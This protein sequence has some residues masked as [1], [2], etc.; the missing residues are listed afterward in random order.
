MIVLQKGGASSPRARGSPTQT[1][2]GP[3]ETALDGIDDYAALSLSHF[4]IISR[5]RYGTERPSATSRMYSI[6]PIRLT[7]SSAEVLLVCVT[8][9]ARL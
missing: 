9:V 7:V 1:E 6:A 5:Q 2:N 3:P 8:T 4:G